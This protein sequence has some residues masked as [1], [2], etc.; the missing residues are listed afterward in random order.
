[1]VSLKL[2]CP[3]DGTGECPFSAVYSR[4]CEYHCGEDE[5]EEDCDYEIEQD[6]LEMGFDP[7]MG[8]Y[9]DDC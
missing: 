8:C 7:Y 2:I 5:P 6:L 3:C 9:T 4:D 1:M